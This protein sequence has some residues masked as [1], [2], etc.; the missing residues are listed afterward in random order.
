MTDWDGDEY[1]K[2]FDDL[3]AGGVDVHGEVGFVMRY[4]P[5]S[6]LDAGCGS[7]RVAIELA[8]RGVATVVGADV[9]PSMLAVAAERGPGVE[10]IESDLAALR[11]ERAFDVVVMA[12]NVPLFTPAGTHGALVRGCARH[13][14]SNGLLI[15][16]FQL[17]RGYEIADYDTHAE[18]A[19][20]ALLE[21]FASWDR[22]EFPGDGT[23]AVSVHRRVDN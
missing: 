18:A 12:G 23:Y 16:G 4:G 21:R 8:R 22:D 17:G 15:A 6:V 2:R 19:G 7:G 10:W 13:V 9:N 20:L 3:A 1:Q 11:L 5:H 14:A